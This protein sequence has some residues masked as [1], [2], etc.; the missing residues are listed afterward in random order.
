MYTFVTKTYMP[1]M[2]PLDPDLFNVKL[3]A[4]TIDFIELFFP[5][6]CAG[7]VECWVQDRS[8]WLLPWNGNVPL[9]G[10][11]RVFRINLKYELDAAPY[12]LVLYGYNLDDLYPHTIDLGIN[13]VDPKPVKSS[14]YLGYPMS[15]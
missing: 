6:G 1:G 10:D 15:E 7:L 4:G 11:N 14:D 9:S 12:E 3:Q 5:P 2:D 8:W 13:V